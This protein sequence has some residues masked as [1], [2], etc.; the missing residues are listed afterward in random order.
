MRE[1]GNK[2]YSLRWHYM[3]TKRHPDEDHKQR[4][5]SSAQRVINE[6]QPHVIIAVADNAQ[7]AMRPYI[8][9]AAHNI[10]FSGVVADPAKYGLSLIHI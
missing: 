8:N 1:L 6:W 4:A 3:D 9:E 7:D 2:P 5:I 10:V